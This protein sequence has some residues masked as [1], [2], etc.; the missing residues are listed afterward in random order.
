MT[1]ETKIGLLVGLAF[2]IVIGILLSD[3]LTTSNEPAQA[4]LTT[5]GNNVRDGVTVPGAGTAPPV[6]MVSPGP[7]SPVEPVPTRQE[8]IPAPTPPIRMADVPADTGTSFTPTPDPRVSL[9]DVAPVINNDTS[10]GADAPDTQIGRNGLREI[11]VRQGEEI[12]GLG[13][14]QPALPVTSGKAYV[15]QLGDTMH[16]IVARQM[17]ANTKTNRDAFL[18]ANP[19]LASNPNLIVA[20]KTYVVPTAPATTVIPVSTNVI[21]QLG[22]GPIPSSVIAAQTTRPSGTVRVNFEPQYWYTV[23]PGDTLWGIAS[24][25]LGNPNT[26]ASIK[27]LNRDVLKGSDKIVTNMKLRLPARPIASVE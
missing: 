3:H 2:I 4:P 19:A 17:G 15:A 21:T 9:P 8:L 16:K 18:R 23:K 20:G 1:R 25:Q 26:I 13:Q 7:V 10:F 24:Q 27:E 5:A 12:V 14:T 6:R 11:S 22:Q